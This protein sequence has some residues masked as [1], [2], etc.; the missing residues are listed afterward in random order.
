M[1]KPAPPAPQAAERTVREPP[2]PVV[3][4]PPP[5]PREPTPSSVEIPITFSADTPLSGE[6]LPVEPTE[7]GSR[8]LDFEDETEVQASPLAR[9]YEKAASP[10]PRPIE[11]DHTTQRRGPELAAEL[12]GAQRSNYA[13]DNNAGDTEINTEIGIKAG[14]LRTRKKVPSVP[15][16]METQIHSRAAFPIPR[17][18]PRKPRPS[19]PDDT[20]KMTGDLEQRIQEARERLHDDGQQSVTLPRAPKR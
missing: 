10:L 2:P 8:H 4:R 11:D 14:A 15:D 16:D 7:L 1:R 6:N 12:A 9:H 18:P 3:M 20:I 5:R 13:S 17:R 19:N